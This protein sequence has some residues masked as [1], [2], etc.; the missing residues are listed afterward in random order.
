MNVCLFS[1]KQNPSIEID[2]KRETAVRVG[3]SVQILCSSKQALRV[4][5]VEI[6]GEISMVLNGPE[7]SEDGI[8]YYGNGINNGQC[9]VRI[10]RVKENHDGIF[11]CSLTPVNSRQEATASLKIIVASEFLLSV[12]ICRDSSSKSLNIDLTY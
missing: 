3:E 11:K 4:C 7:P 1:A 6:P 8:E 12:L 10:A 2:P 9:G 5:R